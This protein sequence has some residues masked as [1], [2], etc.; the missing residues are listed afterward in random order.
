M[1]ASH[2]DRRLAAVL[3]A[4]VVGYSRLLEQDE[5]RTVGRLKAHRAEFIDPLVAEHRGRVV[6]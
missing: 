5:D 4:D 2:A 6:D 3:T 1:A